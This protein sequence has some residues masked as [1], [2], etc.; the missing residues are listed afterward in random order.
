MLKKAR[1]IFTPGKSLRNTVGTLNLAAKQ[2]E[3]AAETGGDGEEERPG[4]L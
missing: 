2:D 3:P 1:V 4:E